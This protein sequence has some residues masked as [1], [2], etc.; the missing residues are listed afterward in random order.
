[1]ARTA[2]E[3]QRIAAQEKTLADHLPLSSEI[4]PGVAKLKG[5][6]GYLSTFEVEGVDFDTCG[7]EQINLYSQQL[8]QFLVSLSG[9][10]YALWTHKLHM[11]VREQLQ[12]QFSNDFSRKLAGQYRQRLEQSRLM[13]T[14]LYVTVIYRPN[15]LNPI[16]HMGFNSLK[17]LAAMERE[18]IEVLGDVT[19]RI[20]TS[21]RKF[22][23]RRLERF[24]KGEREF[25]ELLAFLGF[26]INGYWQDYPVT[27]Y[28]LGGYLSNT[29]ITAGN[30][31]GVLQ[32]T[33]PQRTRYVSCL[34]LKE[35]PSSVTPLS[36]SKLLYTEQEF[37]ETQSFS[38]LHDRT[39]IDRLRR[40]RGQ[41]NAGGE[42]SETEIAEFDVSMEEVKAGSLV[43]GEYHYSI[44]VF[45]DTLD[46]IKKDRAEVIADLEA[47]YFRAEVQ[48]TIPEA[49]WFFQTPGNWKYR[50]REA[51]LTSWNFACLCPMHNFMSGKK[52]GNPWGEAVCIFDSPSGQPYFFSFHCSPEGHDSTDDKL[53]GNTSLFGATGVGKTTF[54]MFVLAHLDKFGARVMV[55]DMDRSNEIA[56]RRMRGTYRSFLRGEPTGINPFQWPDSLETRAFCRALVIQCVT[57]GTERLPAD[58]ESRITT[59]VE[60]VFNMRPETRRLAM[61]SQVLPNTE[62]NSLQARLA[63]WVNDGDLAWVLDNPTD[64]LDLGQARMFGYD[65]SEFID[66]QQICAVFTMCLLRIFEDLIDGT[67][68]A[69]VMEEFWKPLQNPVFAGFV[70]DKLKTIRKENGL[71]L[72]TTQQ[73]DDVLQAPLAKTVVQQN[74]TAIFLPNPKAYKADYVDGFKLTEQEFDLVRSLPPHSR[75]FLVKQDGKS[76][77]ARLDL[78][79][80]QDVIAFLSGDRETVEILDG[81]RA[82]VGD[83]PDDWE[84]P[85]LEAV[86]AKRQG[87]K[88]ANRAPTPPQLHL[89]ETR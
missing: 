14:A 65:Y 64:T 87:K 8:H 17:E 41:L 37:I 69:L 40:Q 30:R 38:I 44:A 1:M 24:Q 66:D 89:T 61:V 75:A 20:A 19:A 86:T 6:N 76:A 45:S 53:P 16:K 10:A 88:A 39:A 48:T 85:F 84:T 33:M 7:P 15:E 2:E 5:N 51:L 11:Q 59:A 77:I 43:V 74:V 70:Q 29:R 58:D 79:G 83:D 47:A 78:T 55:L 35:Y 3:L 62:R 57:N 12:D 54:Q 42:A 46:A 72:T 9:G 63:R 56:I 28:R 13:R 22:K 60:T 25:S 26:L 21:L 73:P 67:P 31:S 49:A 18:A 80:M 34:E 50:T 81:I 82:E 52:T 4:A 27:N 71:V 68:I 32:L 23:P 36:L